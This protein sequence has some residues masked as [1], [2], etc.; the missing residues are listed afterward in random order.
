MTTNYGDHA[1]AANLLDDILAAPTRSERLR[2]L[3]EG[4][5]DAREEERRDAARPPSSATPPET[6][7]AS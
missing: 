4:F 1:Q 6:K 3:A 7:E 2:L 5:A